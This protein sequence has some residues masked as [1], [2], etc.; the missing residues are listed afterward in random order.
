MLKPLISTQLARVSLTYLS[1]PDFVLEMDFNPFIDLLAIRN[2][3]FCMLHY[4]AKPFGERRWGIYDS[5]TDNYVSLESREVNIHTLPRLLQV[6][7]TL[8]KS[9]PTAILYFPRSKLIK[10]GCHSIAPL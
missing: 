2:T 6:D 1:M 8:V 5:S 3:R 4:Q 10:N 7:E 9:V